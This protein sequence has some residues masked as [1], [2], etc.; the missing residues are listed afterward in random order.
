[1]RERGGVIIVDEVQSGFGRTGDNFWAFEGHGIVPEIVVMA[2]GIG[3]GFPL[4]AV[5]AQ[6]HVADRLA[7]KFSFHTYGASPMACAAGRA[8]LQ[9][10]DEEKLQV[11]SKRVGEK[12]KQ[13]LERLH[14][15]YEIVGASAA[16]A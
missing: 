16:M 11:N 5:V 4:G 8:V 12:L 10:I 9:V 15:K 13:V 6:R 3:N 7:G 14:Q 1:M 2:K